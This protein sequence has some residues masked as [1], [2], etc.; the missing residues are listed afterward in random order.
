[1]KA[2]FAKIATSAA[3]V[4]AIG[5][6]PVVASAHE[7][8]GGC[9][10]EPQEMHK[11][12]RHHMHRHFKMLA[13]EL[14]LSQQQKDGIKAIFKNSHDQFKPLMEQMKTERHNLHAL[15]TADTM[16]EAAIRAQ[17]AKV[18][19][20]EANMAVQRAKVA[21]QVRKL[22]TPDQAKKFKELQAKHEKGMNKECHHGM[23]PTDCDK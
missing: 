9:C 10:C 1:M 12:M 17:S 4:A 15:M 11:D 21:Q 3:L 13:K 8:E 2:V 16:D 22:L 6:A 7:H 20:I 5:L 19:A 18:S 14:G 23:K